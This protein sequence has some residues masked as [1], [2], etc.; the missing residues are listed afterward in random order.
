MRGSPKKAAERPIEGRL[1]ANE[2]ATMNAALLLPL[3]ALI[4]HATAAL[5][6]DDIR[7]KVGG[8][9][10]ATF[11]GLEIDP[12]THVYGVPFGASEDDFIKA[13]GKPDGYI[14]LND[15]DTALLYG[16]SHAF[17]FEKGKL[18]GVR[19]TSQILD[20]KLANEFQDSS[21]FDNRDWRLSNGVFMGMNLKEIRNIVG[22]KLAKSDL[23]HH[24][25]LTAK[26]RVELD[27]AQYRD[28]GDGDEV[29]TLFGIYVR[30]GALANGAEGLPRFQRRAGRNSPGGSERFGGI[31]ARLR[32]DADSGE[33]EILDVTPGS[34]AAKAQLRKGLFVR[35]IDDTPTKGK[36]LSECVEVL[37]G[38]PG[39][40]VKLEILDPGEN[41]SRM[42]ELTREEILSPRYER[43]GG[44]TNLAVSADQVLRLEATNG[45][46]AVIQ[47]LSFTTDGGFGS[48][49]RQET[50]TYRWRFRAS[51]G[52][53]ILAGTN[54][55][56]D[57]YTRK[58]IGSNRFELT[59]KNS[60]EEAKVK[61]G[62]LAVEWSYGSTNKGYI[63]INP[64]TLKATVHD[65]SEFE[66]GP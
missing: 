47:F 26:A 9:S 36:Q 1:P 43:L 63:R 4:L 40:G 16:R 51:P 5:A 38:A 2:K 8:P 53:P 50:A 17:V 61:A 59:P 35:S 48:G 64:S 52:A 58:L 27:F 10:R 15:T 28:R 12:D 24:Y 23:G 33:L 25:Y 57:R 20:W 49:D 42:V 56:V 66:K 65:L 13:H 19:I 30:Q 7:S 45:A 14:R 21:P 41:Q 22:N 29:Y 46:R 62:E 11:R 37:R 39:T 34:P 54:T 55:A 3:I 60:R 32:M 31:G 18:M 44:L 6:A